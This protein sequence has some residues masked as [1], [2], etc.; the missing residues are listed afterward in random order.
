M[1]G[2][3]NP[4]M[5]ELIN[6]ICY[7]VCGDDMTVTMAVEGDEPDLNVWEPVIIKNLTEEFRLLGGGMQKF[8]ALCI[9]GIEANVEQ[10]RSYA[11]QTMANATVASALLGSPKGTEIAQKAVAKGKTVKEVVREIGAFSESE[12]DELFDPLMMTDWTR[13]SKLLSEE[14]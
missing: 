12:I 11:E 4:V 1:P 2:K 13:S 3:V 7:Q 8:A 9:D 10:C 5:P 6:Q 14:K